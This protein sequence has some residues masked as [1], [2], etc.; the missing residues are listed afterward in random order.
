MNFTQ[1]RKKYA[2]MVRDL[3]IPDPFD[4]KTF[5][6]NLTLLIDKPV[7]LLPQ[8]PHESD[9]NGSYS[10]GSCYSTKEGHYIAYEHATSQLHQEH[11]ILHEIGHLL[12]EHVG[13]KRENFPARLLHPDLDP[14]MVDG[15]FRRTVYLEDNEIE[16]ELIASMIQTRIQRRVPLRDHE[17]TPEVAKLVKMLNSTF[18]QTEERCRG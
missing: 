4:I 7:H 13:G 8:T 9:S 6:A 18:Q 16:A 14:K 3:D 12:F 5:C 10:C 17:V 11:I 1:R 15:F 2:A